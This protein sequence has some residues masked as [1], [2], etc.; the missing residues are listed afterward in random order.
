RSDSVFSKNPA[1]LSRAARVLFQSGDAANRE[2]LRSLASAP[3][4]HKAIELEWTKLLAEE[5]AEAKKE[6]QRTRETARRLAALETR[7]RQAARPLRLNQA[8]VNAAFA[9]EV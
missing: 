2:S 3:G 8:Q 9:D 6:Q 1:A 5:K 4:T 7:Q